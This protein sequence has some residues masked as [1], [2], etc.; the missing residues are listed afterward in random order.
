MTIIDSNSTIKFKYANTN[1][2]IFLGVPDK[3]IAN[4][5]ST[6]DGGCELEFS[7][8]E[9][10]IGI[11]ERFALYLYAEDIKFISVVMWEAYFKTEPERAKHDFQ[12][13]KDNFENT[14]TLSNQKNRYDQKNK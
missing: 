9:L 10:S 13:V 5:G 2:A 4:I 3:V 8:S 1:G 14:Q 6:R 7:T 12:V 11:K